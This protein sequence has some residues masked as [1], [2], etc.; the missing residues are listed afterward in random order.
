MGVRFACHACGKRL[1]IKNDLAGRRGVCP[2]CSVRF[3]IPTEDQPESIAIDE[4]SSGSHP[5]ELSDESD[6]ANVLDSPDPDHGGEPPDS[7]SQHESYSAG[8]SGGSTTIERPKVEAQ[9]KSAAAESSTASK[10][11]QANSPATILGDSTAV[12]YVRPPSGGQYGPADGPTM[13]QWITEGRISDSAMLWRDGWPDWK[14]AGEILRLLKH[15]GPSIETEPTQKA[16]LAT[17]GN[18]H[19]VDA[20]LIDAPANRD[21]VS[22]LNRGGPLDSSKS[23]RSRKRIAATVALILVLVLLVAALAFV[24]L[25]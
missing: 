2:S 15:K 14:P 13:K 8:T 6:P 7:S 21:K 19:L 3:R 12:W 22:I 17:P 10:A 23:K 16:I 1:N 4:E 24:V 20:S 11:S 9:A 18:A 25:R 5:P